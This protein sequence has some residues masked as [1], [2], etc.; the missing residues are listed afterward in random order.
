MKPFFSV[1]P[2]IG[3]AVDL[4]VSLGSTFFQWGM[5]QHGHLAPWRRW[6]ECGQLLVAACLWLCMT[7]K[8]TKQIPK[9]VKLSWILGLKLSFLNELNIST[10]PGLPQILNVRSEALG[11]SRVFLRH[12]HPP[13]G[14]EVDGQ[15]RRSVNS[16]DEAV[17][18]FFSTKPQ[19]LRAFLKLSQHFLRSQATKS[20]CQTLT[21]CIPKVSLEK[22]ELLWFV[23]IHIFVTFSTNIIF[24]HIYTILNHY[25]HF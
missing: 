15:W 14:I 25:K 16:I 12:F 9:P 22:L 2:L 11:S 20:L 4:L 23:C 3:I 17:N 18:Q 5:R 21:L 6:L 24:K 19:I 10:V 1:V 8:Y 13:V 7:Y